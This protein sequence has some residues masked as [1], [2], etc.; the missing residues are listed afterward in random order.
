[1]PYTRSVTK[2]TNVLLDPSLR[3]IAKQRAEERGLSLSAYVR[4]LIRSDYA[5]AAGA[6]ADMTALVGILGDDGEPTDI[7]GNKHEMVRAASDEQLR[8]KPSIAN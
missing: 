4:E 7:G 2:P 5:E 1:M 8:S 6:S 3:A